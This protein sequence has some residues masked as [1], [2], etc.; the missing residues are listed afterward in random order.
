MTELRDDSIIRL[1]CPIE[2]LDTVEMNSESIRY[3]F[4]WKN[5]MFPQ[6]IRDAQSAIVMRLALT[7][8]FGVTCLHPS[9]SGAQWR[10]N[11]SLGVGFEY[12]DN[13]SLVDS[14]IPVSSVSGFLVDVGAVISYRSALS[15][16]V[17]APSV[18]VR[19]YDKDELDSNDVLLDFDYE[20]TGRLSKFQIRGFVNDETVR[21]AETSGVDFGI[22]NPDEIPEDASGR[23]LSNDDRLLF[24]IAPEWSRQLG[25]RSRLRVGAYYLDA[26]YDNDGFQSYTDFTETFARAA[27]EYDLSE[28]DTISFGGYAR[29][30][31]FEDVTNDLDGAGVAVGWSRDLSENTHFISEVGFDSSDDAAGNSRDNV[32]GEISLVH[33]LQTSRVL[34][35]YRRTVAGSGLGSIYL[36]DSFSLNVIRDLSEK[37]SI[38]AGAR[39][40]QTSGLDDG[41]ANFDEQDY[42]QLRALLSWRLTRVFDVELGYS[43][44]TIDR[45]SASSDADSNRIDLWFRYRPRL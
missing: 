37:L 9:P 39:A 35:S 45:D 7:L 22:E 14:L 29:R 36:R 19:K 34:A 32:I 8:V 31:K 11:P 18:L 28:K 41:A 33:R 21:V 13:P 12:D 6:N 27:I 1:K 10:L 16:F 24:R 26:S 3:Q 40:Y 25:Q 5:R 2:G 23:V 15:S 38:G 43:Y 17:L 30:D 4:S 44:T 42:L 20:Y